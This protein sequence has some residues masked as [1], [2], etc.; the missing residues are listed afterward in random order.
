MR[1][2]CWYLVLGM[3]LG[4]EVSDRADP[5]MFLMAGGD[6]SGHVQEESYLGE[7]DT[8]SYPSTGD[9]GGTPPD[10]NG[11]PQDLDNDGVPD[12]VDN[13]LYPANTMLWFMPGYNPWQTDGDE[14]GVGDACEP[15]DDPTYG[16]AIEVVIR[17][18]WQPPSPGG[19][20]AHV[21][22]HILSSKGYETFKSNPKAAYFS[23]ED[24]WAGNPNPES[25]APYLPKY[26]KGEE[27][28]EEILSFVIPLNT[29]D[30]RVVGV[31]TC[32]G[33][34]QVKVDAKTAGPSQMLMSETMWNVLYINGAMV[35]NYLAQDI[36]QK[37]QIPMNQEC[38]TWGSL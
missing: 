12:D 37:S 24:F 4:C 14:D 32:D 15:Y 7:A 11:E 22:L 27:E 23:K 28:G 18:L 13:C 38:D 17:A 10:T 25:W 36:G 29:T 34:A 8:S 16:P 31:L 9:T 33:Q 21:N 35:G 1:I 30:Q 2:P 3:L 6:A 19:I 5:Q 20:L 26:A